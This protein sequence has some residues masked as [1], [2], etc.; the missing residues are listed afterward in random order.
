MNFDPL[1]EHT[2]STTS[3]YRTKNN[4]YKTIKSEILT[5][6]GKETTL[7]SDGYTVNDAS[8]NFAFSTNALGKYGYSFSWN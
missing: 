5:A 2:I 8:A 3:S 1:K 4:D 6:T 7:D